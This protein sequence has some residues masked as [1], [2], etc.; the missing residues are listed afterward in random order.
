MLEPMYEPLAA[1]AFTAY[2]PGGVP[3]GAVLVIVTEALCPGL[4]V[5]EAGENPVA[6]PEG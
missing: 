1:F 6:Q 5:T 3:E 4:R 2:V